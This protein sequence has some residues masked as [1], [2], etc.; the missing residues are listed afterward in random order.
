MPTP[1]TD[2]DAALL[3]GGAGNASPG[4]HSVGVRRPYSGT[5]GEAGNRQV[6]VDCR[7]AQRTPARPVAPKAYPP[8]EW[9]RDPDRLRKAE[10]PGGAP[11][12][13]RPATAPDL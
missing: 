13:T 2:G 5:P 11:L 3:S 7:H 12:R 10:V 9:A 6:T 4:K 8:R 1:P